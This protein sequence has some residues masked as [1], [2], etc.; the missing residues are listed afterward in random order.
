M[1]VKGTGILSTL[2]FIKMKFGDDA[3][4]KIMPK[5]SEEEQ[6]VLNGAIV[7]PE[8][9]PFSI[10]VNLTRYMDQVFGVGDL[11]L[12]KEIGLWAAEHD[13]KTVYRV[14]YKL[15]TPQFIIK[16]A[17]RIFSTYFD[18]GKLNIVESEKGRVVAELE[19]FPVDVH[20]A[21]LQRVCGS[22]EKMLL[23]SG[24]NEPRV[25][26]SIKEEENKKKIIFNAYWKAD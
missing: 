1:H 19:D 18:R 9:Y 23:L 22:M 15:G 16:Q 4:E 11:T 21:F 2:E 12:A 7:N 20:P 24:G 25:W 17:G 26:V 10:Y 8:W 6:E 14:F 13:L 3:I 5:L